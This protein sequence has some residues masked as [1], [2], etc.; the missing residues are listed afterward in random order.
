MKDIKVDE[1]VPVCFATKV[2][3]APKPNVTW[4]KDGVELIRNPDYLIKYHGLDASLQIPRPKQK[5]AGKFSV[6]AENPAGRAIIDVFL[7]VTIRGELVLLLSS[8]QQSNPFSLITL[9][10]KSLKQQCS[11]I[12]CR[13]W[14]SFIVTVNCVRY[15]ARILPTSVDES[16]VDFSRQ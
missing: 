3:G 12:V 14:L 6:A 1:G 16:K 4:Y 8:L 7:T 2:G 10:H 13:G 11:V 9:S 5:D 15:K